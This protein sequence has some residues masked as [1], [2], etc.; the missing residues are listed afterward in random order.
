MNNKSKRLVTS[1][2][3]VTSLI[4]TSVVFVSNLHL[5]EKAT[6]LSSKNVELEKQY[7]D[8]KK[9]Y[10]NLYNDYRVLES[11]FNQIRDILYT[12][13]QYDPNDITQP[14]QATEYHLTK[15][16][17]GTDLEQYASTFVQAEKDYGIN[18]IVLAS[19]VANESSWGTSD[20][21][22]KDNNYT[23]YAVYSDS[24]PGTKFKSPE[25]CIL[26]T[27]KLLST[28]YVNTGGKH[29]EGSKDIWTVNKTYSTDTKWS[30]TIINIANT[31]VK[32]G[33]VL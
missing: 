32:K 25:D 16:L 10:D 23:G 15:A 6:E 7:K 18:A 29:Y 20:R 2:L 26:T 28:D 14:S 8:T 3:L 31:L 30:S 11:N 19:L 1:T 24:S 21:A 22:K 27:A 4:S 12:E 5:H 13:L 33:E 9:E 17:V